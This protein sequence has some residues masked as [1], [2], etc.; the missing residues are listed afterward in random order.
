MGRDL[1]DLATFRESFSGFLM[2]TSLLSRK[3]FA[4]FGR[5]DGRAAHLPDYVIDAV[6]RIDKEIIAN[7]R[8]LRG[9]FHWAHT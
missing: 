8:P 2:A 7:I 4:A 5:I 1:A 9:G 3:S 6:A